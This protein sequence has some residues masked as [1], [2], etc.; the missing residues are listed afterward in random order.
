M[1]WGGISSCELGHFVVLREMITG[2]HYRSILTHLHPNLQNL[3]LRERSV[4][5]VDNINVHMSHL[6]QNWL[7]VHD[8]EVMHLMWHPQ[9]PE[10]S[11]I[12]HLRD[13]LENK[14][15]ADFQLYAYYPTALHKE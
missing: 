15:C 5:Q 1:V 4:F 6:V 11:I 7:H 8:D 9:S 13:F 2:N 12:E 3:S 10:L 14:I